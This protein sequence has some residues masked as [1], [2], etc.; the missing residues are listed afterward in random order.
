MREDQKQRNQWSTGTEVAVSEPSDAEDCEFEP[1]SSPSCAGDAVKAC[2]NMVNEDTQEQTANQNI[3]AQ[4]MSEDEFGTPLDAAVVNALMAPFEGGAR[5]PL[6]RDIPTTPDTSQVFVRHQTTPTVSQ[7][8]NICSSASSLLVPIATPHTHVGSQQC[9]GS[10][11]GDARVPESTVKRMKAPCIDTDNTS[12]DLHGS[13]QLVG[14]NANGQPCNGDTSDED[15]RSPLL[16]RKLQPPK[17]TAIRSELTA[18]VQTHGSTTQ[19]C[20]SNDSVAESKFTVASLLEEA[21]Q[22]QRVERAMTEQAI[23]PMVGQLV[24]R[25]TSSHYLGSCTFACAA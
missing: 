15:R 12:P 1:F 20:D 22:K 9:F 19:R 2:V 11:S 10:S 25:S 3:P 7:N 17:R 5:S 8:T 18:K 16:L 24:C 14:S 13:R 23:Q 6:S 21:E 4:M